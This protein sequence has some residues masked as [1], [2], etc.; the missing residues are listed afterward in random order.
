M[1]L[2]PDAPEGR[3]SFKLSGDEIATVVDLLCR[4]AAES[5]MLVTAGMLEVPMTL[6]L[7]KK[8]RRLKRELG[9]TNLDIQGEF[10]LLDLSHDDPKVLGR[11]DVVLRFLHQFGD[12]EAYLAVEC[13][14]V[15]DGDTA[16]SY[17]YVSEGVHRFATAKYS[18]GHHCGIMLGYV[19]KLPAAA[20]VADIDDRIQ[21]AYGEDAKLELLDAH[22]HSLAMQIGVLAQGTQGHVIR[23]IHIF[24]DMTPFTH[25][26]EERA[27]TSS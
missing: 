11:I 6:H 18:A 13:K 9:L 2:L 10:E 4:A 15:A 12:E 1:R 3:P 19:V 8:M 16:L 27:T 14:R 24:V 20:L 21:K 25:A 17:L 26:K 22:G 7:K 23:L 5:R